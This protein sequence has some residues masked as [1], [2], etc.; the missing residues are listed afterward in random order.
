MENYQVHEAVSRSVEWYPGEMWKVRLVDSIKFSPQIWCWRTL[1]TTKT[2]SWQRICFIKRVSRN[3]DDNFVKIAKSTLIFSRSSLQHSTTSRKQTLL[4][5]SPHATVP[6]LTARLNVSWNFWKKVFKRQKQILT[7][8]CEDVWWHTTIV[9]I[10]LHYS[11]AQNCSSSEYVQLHQAT[12]KWK[13]SSIPIRK[14]NGK[15]TMK[16]TKSTRHHREIA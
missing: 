3:C 13:N 16:K 11:A 12:R 9:I 7:K 4:T 5:W 8:I 6:N 10:P 1:I 15:H 2:S 14:P